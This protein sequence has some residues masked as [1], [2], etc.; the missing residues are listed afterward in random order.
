[1]NVG[2][3]SETRG[4]RLTQQAIIVIAALLV[5]YPVGWLLY[6]SATPGGKPGL[7]AYVALF[8]YPEWLPFKTVAAATGLVLLPL[9]SRAT[10]AASPP[11]PATG[12]RSL[13]SLCAMVP[14]ITPPFIGGSRVGGARRATNR[15]AQSRRQMAGT[16]RTVAQYLQPGRHDLLPRY[17]CRRMSTC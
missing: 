1:V 13:I 16:F 9:V 4:E 15:P 10:A 11:R 3:L 12:G 8:A 7:D 5:I 2:S 17:L 14:L 6:A